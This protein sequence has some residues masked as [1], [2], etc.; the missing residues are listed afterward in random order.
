MLIQH[1]AAK[2]DRAMMQKMMGG[3]LLLSQYSPLHQRYLISEWQ[4]RIMP[5]FELNQFCYYEDEQGRPIAFCNW[6]FLSEQ[7]RELLLSGER[8][9]EAADWCSGDHIYIPE[10][11][12]PFGHGRQIVNDLRQRVFLPWKG[13]KV[14]T[15]RGKIDTQNDRCI[16]KVQWFSI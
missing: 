13:Q 12:A 7:V 8:E 15:V 5:S 10:M 14:C 3:I 6:A 1:R 4:Q 16:R 2:L 11:L 9:I